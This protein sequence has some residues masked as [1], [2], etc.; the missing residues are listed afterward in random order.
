M[1]R[2]HRIIAF[3]C[4]PIITLSLGWQIGARLERNN[5]QKTY[6]RLEELYTSGNG[7][8]RTIIDPEKEVNVDVLWSV[9]R[10]LLTHYI[11]PSMLKPQEMVLGAVRGMVNAVNDP[12]TVFMD[13]KEN[14]EFHQTLSGDL[15]G[16]GAELALRSGRVLVVAPLKGSPA[17]RAGLHPQDVIVKVNDQDID[18]KSLQEVVDKIRGKK[19]TQVK[20]T[21]AR[22]DAG[23]LLTFTITREE[24]HVPSVQ[25]EIR[26]TKTGSVALLTI[27]KF[28]GDTIKEATKAVGEFNKQNADKK[29]KG[30]IIDLRF[31]GG[32]YLDGAV[33]LSSLFLR[34]GKVVSVEGRDGP[35]QRHYVTG[36]PLMPDLPIAV[37]INEGTASASEIVSGALQDL[38]RATIIGVKS[39]G[40]GTVQEVLDLPGGSSLRVTI[41]HWLTPLGRNLGK[42]GVTPDIKVERSQQDLDA[43][44]D[45]QMNAALEWLL[46][47]RDVTKP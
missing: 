2:L 7:S 26:R 5:L 40:K 20:I 1:P 45:P 15:Q 19:G 23:A 4:L 12:Y 17:E 3:L 6:Q 29:L 18:G 25:S 21:V 43:N 35:V 8:G 13:P 31:N 14:D 46:D 34:E 11:D 9:W 36:R 39:F 38:K 41:A 37:L 44:N 30:I 22:A 27:N 10:L 24:I 16:I 47:H 33:A 28:G 32:G 42:E